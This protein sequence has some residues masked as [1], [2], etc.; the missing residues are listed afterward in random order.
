MFPD[1]FY[2]TIHT[3]VWGWIA[4]ALAWALFCVILNHYLVKIAGGLGALKQFFSG[5]KN[6]KKIAALVRSQ[7]E[8]ALQTFRSG[9]AEF[10]RIYRRDPLRIIWPF[11]VLMLP[12]IIAGVTHNQIHASVAQLEANG[13][14]ISSYRQPIFSL[15]QPNIPLFI[16]VVAAA[17]EV[18]HYIRYQ[19]LRFKKNHQK[20]AL[21]QYKWLHVTNILLFNLVIGYSVIYAILTFLDFGSALYFML[22]DDGITYLALHSDQMYGLQPAHQSVLLMIF[23]FIAMSLLPVTILIREKKHRWI[24]FAGLYIGIASVVIVNLVLI[25]QFD[26]RLGQIQ[27]SALQNASMNILP[28][29]GDLNQLLSLLQYQL[30]TEMPGGFPIPDW[31]KFILGFRTLF[32]GYEFLILFSNKERLPSV[33]DLVGVFRKSAD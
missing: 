20:P 26:S 13:L 7:R 18:S 19:H 5:E 28:S 2:S 23:M 1:W 24:Y 15:N 31:M 32:I 10:S 12:I 11:T 21:M 17:Q 29:G 16:I 22:A 25:L 3:T 27:S 4:L 6:L 8:I 30:L 9:A 14:N 33:A